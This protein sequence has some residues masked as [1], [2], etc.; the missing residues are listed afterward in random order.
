MRIDRPIIP[1]FIRS[2]RIFTAVISRL[3]AEA[4]NEFIQ[5]LSEAGID[6]V[7]YLPESWLYEVYQELPKRTEFVT[8][9]TESETT[10][11]CI[12]AGAWL[13]GR[14]PAMIMENSGI[15]EACLAICKLG[16]G[17]RIPLLLLASYRGDVGDQNFWAMPHSLSPKVLEALRIPY[18]IVR[19]TDE[20]RSSIRRARST[21]DASK[22]PVAVLFTGEVVE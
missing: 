7:C 19:R 22:Y 5:G 14:T 11:I 18:I 9:P 20:I 2:P 8:I 1:V 4:V 10:G 3:K 12:C 15:F 17:H 16:I 13:G 21:F 6:F